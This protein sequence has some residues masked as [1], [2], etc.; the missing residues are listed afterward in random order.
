MQQA[1]TISLVTDTLIQLIKNSLAGAWKWVGLDNG[2]IDFPS[3]QYPAIFPAAFIDIVSIDWDNA[4]DNNQVGDCTI[5]V[6]LAFDIPE[7]MNNFTPAK[8]YNAGIT[9]LQWVNDVYTLI[10][11]H[12]P[13]TKNYTR[14]TRVRQINERRADRLKVVRMEFKTTIWDE[15]PYKRKPYYP[16]DRPPLHVLELTPPPDPGVIENPVLVR[17]ISSAMSG[18]ASYITLFDPLIGEDHDIPVGTTIR[19]DCDDPKFADYVGTHVVSFG[20][21][22]REF[23]IDVLFKYDSLP[24]TQTPS[25]M[26]VVLLDFPT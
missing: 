20:I 6:R 10:E 11:N 1:A 13:A 22:D 7:D 9:R 8:Q 5:S 24:A 18:L 25:D 14:F 19:I 17:E 26:Y 3:E 2:E 16:I 23:F 12:N 4:G 15:R 21:S